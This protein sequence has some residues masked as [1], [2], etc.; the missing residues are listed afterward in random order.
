MSQEDINYNLLPPGRNRRLAY[1]RQINTPPLN[2][3]YN[4]YDEYDEYIQSEYNEYDNEMYTIQN[5]YNNEMYTIQNEY[6][7]E[8]Y[9]IENEYNN[10]M[11]TIENENEN[12]NDID[13]DIDIDNEYNEYNEYDNDT[14]ENESIIPLSR[15]ELLNQVL[16][17]NSNYS[18]EISLVRQSR[19]GRLNSEIIRDIPL[20]NQNYDNVGNQVLN[21]LI[22]NS[23]YNQ[24]SQLENVPTGLLSQKL[25]DNS[26]VI[27]NQDLELFCSI[28]QNNINYNISRILFC[29]HSFHI[30]CIDT[31]FVKKNTCPNCKTS[32]N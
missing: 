22:D 11:Y 9:T 19:Y 25:L 26:K 30:N 8:I 10:E 16:Y 7:N 28:C 12:E 2:N 20:Y 15:E 3:E 17:E 1:S 24:L 31:W 14:F 18:Y 6:N 4:E 13:I 5:E 21:R 23:D 27:V 32:L 29:K